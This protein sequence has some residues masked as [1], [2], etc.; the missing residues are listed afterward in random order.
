MKKTILLVNESKFSIRLVLF[1][2]TNDGLVQAKQL[3]SQSPDL[4][5]PIGKDST[6]LK[7]IQV[8]IYVCTPN[9]HMSLH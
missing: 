1:F 5:H 4:Y 6:A 7:L 3:I 8:D 9:S 2:E